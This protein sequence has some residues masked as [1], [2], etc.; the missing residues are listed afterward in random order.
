MPQVVLSLGSNID[1]AVN[2]RKAVASLSS[3]FGEMQIS[4]VYESEAMGFQGDNFLN[5]VVAFESDVELEALVSELKQLEDYQ[6]R[7]R[8]APRFS[9]RTLDIDILTYGRLQGIHA[10][11]HLPRAEI[12]EQAFV[13]KPLADLLPHAL[14][15]DRQVTYGELWQEFD[16]SG[17]RLWQIEFDW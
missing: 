7:D 8:S 11:I 14:H 15:P 17:Q 5:L 10:G 2:I 12:T 3:R 6:G 9:G 16:S 4:P 1:P 13:L